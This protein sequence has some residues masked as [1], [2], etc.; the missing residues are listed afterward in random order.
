MNSRVTSSIEFI[1]VGALCSSLQCQCQWRCSS[2]SA[3][4]ALCRCAVAHLLKEPTYQHAAALQ[5]C[6]CSQ[7]WQA[8]FMQAACYKP[9]VLSKTSLPSAQE[10]TACCPT[11]CPDIDRKVCTAAQLFH[12]PSEQ[13]CPSRC[14]DFVPASYETRS[15]ACKRDTWTWSAATLAARGAGNTH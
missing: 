3:S 14:A 13:H 1:S 5:T 9:A 4:G 11:V 8:A 12:D 15:R 2:C 7:L 6:H 10:P